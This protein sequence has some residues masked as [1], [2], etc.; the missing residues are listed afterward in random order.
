[1]AADVS[2]LGLAGG[3]P[4]SF[5]PLSG[6]EKAPGNLN[7][8]HAPAQGMSVRRH[9]RHRVFHR[10]ILEA[11]TAYAALLAVA[12]LILVC[13]RRLNNLSAT[14]GR[15]RS[16]AG[17]E[18]D[19]PAGA[20]WGNAETS[21]GGGTDHEK[22]LQEAIIQQAKGNIEGY[23][24][25]IKQL[26]RLRG[27]HIFKTL[28]TAT[29]VYVLVTAEMGA[30]GFF[31]D[32]ELMELKARWL[33]V[34]Q[35][36]ILSTVALETGGQ[37]A[38]SNGAISKVHRMNGELIELI[39]T[40]MSAKKTRD[41]EVLEDPWPL[42]Q[43]LVHVQAEAIRIARRY[44]TTIHPQSGATKYPRRHALSKIGYLADARRVMI[45]AEPRL[46]V[47]FEGFPAR[48]LA[49]RRYGPW[50]GDRARAANL[51]TDPTGQ[52]RYLRRHFPEELP[53][54]PPK[55][56]EAVPPSSPPDE[57]PS[58]RQTGPPMHHHGPPMQPEGPPL[59]P[60]GTPMHLQGPPMHLLG[61]PPQTP[62]LSLHPGESR[63][64]PT[65]QLWSSHPRSQGPEPYMHLGA[66]PKYSQAAA[67]GGRKGSGVPS[68]KAFSL[69]THAQHAAEKPGVPQ[70]A[71][72]PFAAFSSTGMKKRLESVSGPPPHASQS[73]ADEDPRLRRAEALD[74]KRAASKQT[75]SSN[76]EE[77]LSGVWSEAAGG[78]SRW[79]QKPVD[80][81][82]Q[83]LGDLI[84]LDEDGWTA[85][86]RG[87][88]GPM[89]PS[90]G[91]PL[92]AGKGTHQPW[93]TRRHIP[94]SS[95]AAPETPRAPQIPGVRPPVSSR[96][97]AFFGG[98]QESPRLPSPRPS[99]PPGF[100]ASLRFAG[101]VTPAVHRPPGPSGGPHGL[102]RP[103][104]PKA[105]PPPG[106]TWPPKFGEQVRQVLQRYPWPPVSSSGPVPPT[107]GRSLSESLLGAV[108]QASAMDPSHPSP[109]ASFSSAPP[110]SS[111]PVPDV[112]VPPHVSPSQ[113]SVRG[114]SHVSPPVS[115]PLGPLPPLSAKPGT[116][117]P[118]SSSPS[119][120]VFPRS[121]HPPSLQPSTDRDP[122]SGTP[123]PA[124]SGP[125][126]KRPSANKDKLREGKS[127]PYH[128]MPLGEPAPSVTLVSTAPPPS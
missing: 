92:H 26:V 8:L 19:E 75:A 14:G 103:P 5:A 76:N 6:T 10:A 39:S 95:W 71:A 35:E 117:N 87:E 126:S 106:F 15:A 85:G 28:T 41:I 49:K 91:S 56:V 73:W 116:W 83:A 47:Y 30:L 115:S 12:F 101:P 51:P 93:R 58:S 74:L 65:S 119:L 70:G 43:R 44:L 52:I 55:K 127:G 63:M 33:G 48:R 2:Q 23:K 94:L 97:G 102:P 50:S 17:A 113:L 111:F 59:D 77:A 72:L 7:L 36:A 13:V 120:Q 61:P 123:I 122:S 68:E 54:K 29:S 108:Q 66:R 32:Y 24:E 11:A 104:F 124:V 114:P 57:T 79:P 64:H 81:V 46:A 84:L 25:I 105:R 69:S 96:G 121:L 40:I 53:L 9:T 107:S 16:L 4:Q 99:P 38:T 20:C 67:P 125:T 60:Q 78:L 18:G 82:A 1:M 3:P 45:L 89:H 110:P 62:R 98:P 34:M 31:I 27:G 37:F 100:S 112:Q 21:D 88:I 22:A 109:L 42:L 80:E 118:L 90:E 128:G 86:D